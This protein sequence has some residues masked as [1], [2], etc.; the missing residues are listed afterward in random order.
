M[1]S[2]FSP[3]IIQAMAVK[4]LIVS[5]W[6]LLL[7]EWFQ[8]MIVLGKKECYLVLFGV[9]VWHRLPSVGISGV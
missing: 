5:E 3:K 9:S 6:N 2:L 4:G 8:A 7:S 1:C